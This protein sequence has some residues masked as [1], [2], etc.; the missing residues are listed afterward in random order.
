MPAAPA[1]GDPVPVGNRREAHYIGF[2]CGPDCR[3]GRD[4]AVH[5]LQ[6]GVSWVLR[7]PHVVR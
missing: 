2:A 1:G 4:A 7:N 3:F 5:A 6:D